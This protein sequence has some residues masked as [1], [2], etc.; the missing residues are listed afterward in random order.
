MLDEQG[1]EE[2]VF[3][4]YAE[5]GDRLFRMERLS[6]YDDAGQNADRESWLAG[7][8]DPAP[9]EEWAQALADD[10]RRGLVSRRAR[11]LSEE[12]T[13]DEAM[14]CHVALP[15]ISRDQE[16]RVLHRGEH[17]IP[18]LLDHDYWVIE[19]ARGPVA[20]VRMVYSSGGAFLG[21]AP[22][23]PEQHDLYLRERELAWQIGEPFD[24]WW[25]HHRELRRP[26]AA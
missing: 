5:A 19:P 24:Q 3:S 10:R 26:M 25:A 14:S 16:I 2:F 8:F 20:V 17:P 6:H 13:D 9:L 11:V 18:A 4:R 23:A 1:L 15:I 22:V 7:R 21:A 12:L